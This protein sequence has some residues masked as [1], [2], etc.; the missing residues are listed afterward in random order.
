MRGRIRFGAR[1]AL[2]SRASALVVALWV[3]AV[4]S[5]M[6][7]SFA[8]EA[9]LQTGINVYVRERNRVNRL[10][11]AGQALAEVVIAGFSEAKDWSE[12]EDLEE[13]L[14]PRPHEP[15]SRHLRFQC[16]H[17][18]R[19]GTSGTGSIPIPSSPLDPNVDTLGTPAGRYRY[20]WS[21]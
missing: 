1:G 4:L 12:D 7:L 9:H 18:P 14:E 3:I 17:G 19:Q 6:V 10:V 11:D 15:H 16:A 5:V 21:R 2:A 13:L 8:T 20:A